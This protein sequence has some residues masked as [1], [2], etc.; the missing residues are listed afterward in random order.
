MTNNMVN[1]IIK[2]TDD[3]T[4]KMVTSLLS[5]PKMLETV[6]KLLNDE[7]ERRAAENKQQQQL[8]ESEKKV[9]KYYLIDN[10]DINAYYHIKSYDDKT[11]TYTCDNV[12]YKETNDDEKHFY[13]TAKQL[14]FDQ[15][16]TSSVFDDVKEIDQETFETY[17]NKEVGV[18]R[19]FDN[20]PLDLDLDH[21]FSDLFF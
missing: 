1:D 19:L 6:K 5:N 14:N 8:I 9:G 18:K 21:F 20:R 10:G 11:K 17:F 7:N 2:Q 4:L 13:S 12:C 15:K 16:M 3:E